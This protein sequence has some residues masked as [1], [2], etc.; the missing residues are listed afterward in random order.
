MADETRNTG[1]ENLVV[2]RVTVFRFVQ[3]DAQLSLSR[4]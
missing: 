2:L 3:S 1:M 4:I